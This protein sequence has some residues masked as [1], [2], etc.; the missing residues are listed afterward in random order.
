MRFLAV[1]FATVM[2]SMHAQQPEKNPGIA[3]SGLHSR[4]TIRYDNYGIPLI[5]GANEDDVFFAQGYALA[6]DRLWQ[7]DLLRRSGR[8]ELAEVLGP[9]VVEEDKR[10]RT[11]GF[12]GVCAREAAN[13]PAAY[14]RALDAYTSGVN[15]R[16]SGLTKETLPLE[17]KILG[18][19]PKPWTIE[20][21]LIVGKVFSESLSTSWTTDLLRAQL[22]GLS[23]EKRALLLI[24]RTRLDVLLVG[25]DKPGSATALS[26]KQVPSIELARQG[27]FD[28]RLRAATLGRVG[29]LAGDRSASNS[30]VVSGKHSS[31]GKPLLANDPHLAPSVPGI[32]YMVRLRAPNLKVDGAAL[33]GNPGVMIG[34][35]ERIAWG[36]TN[37]GADVQ[38]LY[39]EQ[40]DPQDPTRYRTPDGWKQTTTRQEQI[41]VRR[42]A[43][44]APPEVVSFTVEETRHGPLI[45]NR[46]GERYALRWTTLEPGAQE[47]AATLVLNRAG[48]W[49]AFLSALREHSG[50]ATNFMYADIDGHIGY[51]AAGW[52]PKRRTL[53][54]TVPYA[55]ESNEGDWLGHIPGDQL[56]RV[57]DPPGGILVTANQRVAG[58]SYPHFLTHEWAQP[59]RAHRARELLQA[60]AR[61]SLA[62]LEQ[63]QADVYAEAGKTFARQAAGILS[64]PDLE[65]F[66]TLLR[67]WDG[68]VTPD[69][70]AA[71][72]IAEMRTALR[73]RVLT[74]VLG[75][76]LAQAFRWTNSGPFVDEIVAKQPKEWLPPEFADY[77]A[78]LRACLDDAKKRLV[79][80]G[81]KTTDWIWGAYTPVRLQHPLA[82]LPGGIGGK[83]S[84]P[85]FP[86]A[87]GGLALPTI[88]VGSGVSLRFVA[89]LSDWNKTKA[90]LP[91]GQ[92]GDPSSPHW[93]DQ[94]QDWKQARNAPF[95]FSG[96]LASTTQILIP[97]EAK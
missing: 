78:L 54:G 53:D 26:I 19:T 48:N 74:A 68:L 95:P 92:S 51:V 73:T 12:N 62:D 8:G 56:P 23:A 22:G 58:D 63:M 36:V 69:S 18:Y 60:K 5:E 17:F 84:I 81:P 88:N 44:D 20:D 31:S 67:D 89:D 28:E 11:L 13:L 80:L 93:A 76:E 79:R 34:H 3:V 82:A 65:E 66:R 59:Y 75:A 4:V 72:L 57:Y 64:G 38:D 6:S 86:L 41:R 96:A 94:L 55:G 32:W 27:M 10:H 9:S 39:R 87:G 1:S 25:H 40:F 14:R 83:F 90:G 15:A 52:I 91:L 24:E 49:R 97:A 46:N 33:P 30:W 61:L 37:L 50:P 47:F 85:A 29:L 16:I 71:P 21:S 45:L 35:N 2:L 77:P 70:Y 43:G 42:G 7:L